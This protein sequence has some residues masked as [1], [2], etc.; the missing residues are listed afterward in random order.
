MRDPSWKRVILEEGFTVTAERAGKRNLTAHLDKMSGMESKLREALLKRARQWASFH[1]WERN[2][3]AP[4][5]ILEDRIAWYAG[6]FELARQLPFSAVPRDIHE[7]VA[8]V[9]KL[10]ARLKHLLSQKRNV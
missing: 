4:P 6:A 2:Q 1:E 9:A 10:H 3:N 7:K 8:A 5:L